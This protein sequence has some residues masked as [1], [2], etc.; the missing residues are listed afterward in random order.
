M[1]TIHLQGI[2]KRNAI[3]SKFL[4]AG[5]VLL[6]NFGYK[7][8]IKEI[9]FSKTNKSLYL[10]VETEDGKLCNRTLRAERLVAVQHLN[11]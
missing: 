1:K 5:M 4:K 3:E 10:T 8:T 9:S 11:Q 2:G 7:S 6:W